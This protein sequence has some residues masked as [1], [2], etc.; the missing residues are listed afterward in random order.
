MI[1][2]PLEGNR[3]VEVG[4][5]LGTSVPDQELGRVTLSTQGE[6]Q[7]ANRQGDPPPHRVGGNA[8]H[9]DPPGVEPAGEE[10]AETAKENRVDVEE[11]TCRHRRVGTHELRPGRTRS[12]RRW[13]DAVT[14][15]VDPRGRDQQGCL[16][17]LRGRCGRANAQA[18]RVDVE[19]VMEK[20]QPTREQVAAETARTAATMRLQA[21]PL[22]VYETA[23]AL[24]IIAPLPA[25]TA[26][27]VTVRLRSGKLHFQASLRSAGPRTYLLH[28]WEYGGYEREVELPDGFGSS[29]EASLANGQ[30]VVRVLRGGFTE[31]IPIHPTAL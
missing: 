22:N 29:V 28:E 4:G 6:A 10:H 18:S 23:A 14:T 30:L 20:S 13:L 16:G 17:A 7:I 31:S 25:V 21:V 3:L 8:T 27:D 24:V 9:M 15:V 12:P 11:V 5:E 26:G 1:R 19:L 2:M